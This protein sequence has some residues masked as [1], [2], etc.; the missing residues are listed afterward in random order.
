LTTRWE[1]ESA[2][3]TSS[4]DGT[5]RLIMLTLLC[6]SVASTA[7][8]PLS[9]AP[10]LDQL[11]SMTG[12]ARSSVAEWMKVL[13]AA[14][15]VRRVADGATA[16]SGYQLSVGEAEVTLP[17]RS[18]RRK[19]PKASPPGGPNV[20]GALRRSGRPNLKLVDDLVRLAD[21]DEAPVSPP[22][23]LTLVRLADQDD[24][25]LVRQ[26]DQTS[27]PGGLTGE[28]SPFSRFLNLEPTPSA[29]RGEPSQPPTPPT[30]AANPTNKPANTERKPT[31]P[32]APLNKPYRGRQPA[33]FPKTI[34]QLPQAT[35]IILNGLHAAG[36]PEATADDA[37]AVHRA[38]LNRYGTRVN[39]SYL[40]TMTSNR[41]FTPIYD[42]IRKNRAKQLEQ[43]ILRLQ[44]THPD[45]KHGTAAGETPH[46]TTGLLLCPLCRTGSS[47][48]IRVRERT[49]PAVAAA[50]TAWRQVAPGRHSVDD[51]MKITAQFGALYQRGLTADQLADYARTIAA[52]RETPLPQETR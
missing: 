26:A 18:S 34:S 45:C 33:L 23:G 43:Q 48:P 2:V 9:H 47:L 51:L 49:H 21:Q 6:R 46:P 22:G 36:H 38:V 25:T 32:V 41:S 5:G 27:P 10:T 11:A 3:F 50:V 4:I 39:A 28:P 52:G 17:K 13:T 19:A 20:D 42:E 44:S 14:G 40:R 30:P 15:W 29:L 1:V 8:V 12:V 16:R 24:E 35:Q 7:E 31:P 37:T